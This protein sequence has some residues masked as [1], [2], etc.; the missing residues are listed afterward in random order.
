MDGDGDRLTLVM[1]CVMMVGMMLPSATPMILTFAMVNRR[2]RERDQPFAATGAFV[3]G[4]LLAWGAFS[5]AATS[6]QWGLQQAALLSMAAAA[7]PVLG[8]PYS[9]PRG[10]IS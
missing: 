10:F 8:A 9:S 4:Y 7:S 5:L 1:W 6:A 3:A 2:K